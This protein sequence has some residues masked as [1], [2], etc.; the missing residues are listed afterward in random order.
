[1]S[2][3]KLHDLF[4]KEV[5]REDHHLFVKHLS[6]IFCPEAAVAAKEGAAKW[7]NRVPWFKEVVPPLTTLNMAMDSE[8]K[9]AAQNVVISKWAMFL[10]AMFYAIPAPINKQQE[11]D[12]IA[13]VLLHMMCPLPTRMA[14]EDLVLLAVNAMA[15][16]LQAA[17][18]TSVF[19]HIDDHCNIFKRLYFIVKTHTANEKIL[20]CSFNALTS[21][22]NI[23]TTDVQT[24]CCIFSHLT[25]VFDVACDMLKKLQH[26]G[27]INNVFR[28]L[29]VTLH[30]AKIHSVLF[31]GMVRPK[32]TVTKYKSKIALLCI[33]Y[34]H[35]AKSCLVVAAAAAVSVNG[36]TKK[37][38]T[39]ICMV[40][41][42]L[43]PLTI[44][45][46]DMGILTALLY[47]VREIIGDAKVSYWI[48]RLLDGT[49]SFAVETQPQT[50]KL[51]LCVLVMR[52]KQPYQE[53]FLIGL[54]ALGMFLRKVTSISRQAYDQ[55]HFLLTQSKKNHADDL[56]LG[57]HVLVEGRLEQMVLNG[58]ISDED[59]KS[60]SKAIVLHKHNL[61]C[62]VCLKEYY[63]RFH[64]IQC[65]LAKYCSATCQEIHWTKIGHDT[66]CTEL[67]AEK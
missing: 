51:I 12:T 1:M 47:D 43:P 9:T 20:M 48:F 27:V 40:L 59:D 24:L 63:L 44:T 66:W 55:I 29:G 30:F 19:Y 58:G 56:S 23:Q 54:H 46:A 41:S 5:S 25:N 39:S 13:N 50:L 33:R 32:A 52:L 38:I 35:I 57:L 2:S 17:A 28:F 64:C 11:L 42:E 31:E 15:N 8:K 53:P 37:I 7:L 14:P 62:D 3:A 4:N 21:M 26:P 49:P 67:F 61:C 36:G 65:K 60:S 10:G 34:M 18:S 45:P 6:T 22:A 16:L